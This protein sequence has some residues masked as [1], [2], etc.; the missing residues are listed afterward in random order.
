MQM[1]ILLNFFITIV[2]VYSE[3]VQPSHMMILHKQTDMLRTTQMLQKFKN[4][5]FSR[6][7]LTI[8]R[9]LEK[10]ADIASFLYFNE[11]KHINCDNVTTCF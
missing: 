8:G 7:K 5:Y 9:D 4:M 1:I 2:T 10:L 6:E 3:T 11:G